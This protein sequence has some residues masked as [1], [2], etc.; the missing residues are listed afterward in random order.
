M[1]E[2]K[3]HADDAE[4]ARADG[5]AALGV[6]PRYAEVEIL[7]ADEHGVTALVTVPVEPP[8]AAP[9]VADIADDDADDEPEDDGNWA[10]DDEEDEDDDE[11]ADDPNRRR[12]DD[13]DDE[14]DDDDWYDE[15]EDEEPD[16]AGDSLEAVTKRANRI[17]GG[18][19]A[20][21]GLD[22][23]ADVQSATEEEITLNVQG[24][25]LGIIIGAAGQTLNSLQFVL[26]LM[27]NRGGRRRRLTIDAEGYRERRR[28]KLEELARDHAQRAKSEHRPV[29]LEGLRAAERRI[30][31]TALQ[32]DPGVVTYSEGEEPNRRL[33]ITPRA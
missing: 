14:E 24:E 6:D 13:D 10:E 8:A 11:A 28:V 18:L 12:D 30:I 23:T 15:D 5:A 22:A 19:L 25:D 33:I 26:N 16:D 1:R 29:I 9:P 4:Q 2:V 3:V 27:V 31:H 17:L 20:R 7:E 32:H 21:M